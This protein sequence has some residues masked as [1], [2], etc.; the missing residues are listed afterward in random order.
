[1]SEG[2]SGAP[3]VLEESEA[4]T[5]MVKDVEDAADDQLGPYP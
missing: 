5:P 4:G 3:E 2:G 1:M